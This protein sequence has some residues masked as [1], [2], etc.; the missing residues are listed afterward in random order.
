MYKSVFSWLF[1]PMALALTA[2]S[3]SASPVVTHLG[4]ATVTIVVSPDPPVVG[5]NAVTVEVSGAPASM[6]KGTVV[7][8]AT[9]MP[10]MNM[11]GPSGVASRVRGSANEWRF[12]ADFGTA[13]AWTLRVELTGALHGVVSAVT[14][15]AAASNSMAAMAAGGGPDASAWRT[16][17][18]ALI[19][20]I[21]IGVLV[22]RRDRRPWTI[23]L[24]VIAGLVVLGMAFAQSQNGSST[25]D[26]ASMQRARGSAPI[27]VTLATVGR[28]RSG[29]TISAPANLQPYLV[30]NIVARAPGVLSNFHAYT[31]DRLTAGE[32][33]AR[34]SE[35]E[36]QSNAQAAQA[37]A[38]AAQDQRTFAQENASSMR[39]DVS[40]AR[41]K[42][43]YWNAEIR[44]ER[45][46][47]R[48][49]AVSVQAYQDERAQ[50]VAAH[51]AYTSALAKVAAANASVS[52]AQ[53]QV[54]QAMAGAQSQNI[55]AGYTDVV[56]PNN[57]IVMKRLVDPGVYVEPGTAVLQVAV[58][59]RL[60][61]QAQVAQQN[62]AEVTIG[63]PIDVIFNDGTVL[64]SH[65]SSV[66]PVV[67][68]RTRTAIAEAIV[69]NPGDRY[70]PGS[71]A[72]AILHT[73]GPVRRNAFSVPSGS[74]VGGASTSV[75]TDVRGMA[76]RVPVTVISNDGTTAQV[77]GNLRAGDRIVVT[78]AS[79]LEEGQP[80]AQSTP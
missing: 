8:Y 20:V 45:S 7:R 40:A 38:R 14:K 54:D 36:L 74:L 46:L 21:L 51:S 70:Q 30:Q 3:A 69:P 34:L 66:S 42:L 35:P 56:A 31:G 76:H 22:L 10:S 59:D 73:A 29:I 75:W 27:P 43:R 2:A 28:E 6:L 33:V 13:A 4:N 49:G 48:A 77:T 79:N 26:M 16:A 24:I 37:A 1:L 61:V 78:G 44:R 67:G 50:A 52:A 15:S 12:H 25:T 23:A 64:H 39:A 72:Q 11:Q 17:T 18:F 58:I 5:S 57:S 80:I 53:A 68:S 62:L 65:I 41:E 60:R 19:A 63:T 55:L 47:L 71:F 9:L 32:I